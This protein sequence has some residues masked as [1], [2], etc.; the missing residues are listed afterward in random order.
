VDKIT[1]Q[2]VAG[3]LDDIDMTVHLLIFI[4]NCHSL[5]QVQ[6]I[7]DRVTQK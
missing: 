5:A 2:Y 1:V 3:T 4:V 6:R 7:F